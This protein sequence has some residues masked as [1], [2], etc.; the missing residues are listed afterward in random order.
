MKK[1]E[2][3]SFSIS[4]IIDSEGGGY[5]NV[6]NALLQKTFRQSTCSGVPNT[7]ESERHHYYPICSMNIR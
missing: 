7:V 2:S 3:Y 5:L 1:C 6:Q 4:Q